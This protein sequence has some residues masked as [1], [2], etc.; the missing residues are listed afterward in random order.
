MLCFLEAQCTHVWTPPYWLGQLVIYLLWTSTWIHR[1]WTS[2]LG[3]Y[4]KHCI[5]CMEGDFT[6]ED[7]T[8]PNNSCLFGRNRNRWM[9]WMTHD[10]WHT[11]KGTG[12]RMCSLLVTDP[13][14]LVQR[15]RSSKRDGPPPPLPCHFLHHIHPDLLSNDYSPWVNW[16]GIV[17]RF[18]KWARFTDRNIRCICRNTTCFSK[19][20]FLFAENPLQEHCTLQK[21][22]LTAWSKGRRPFRWYQNWQRGQYL[23]A[24]F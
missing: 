6:K 16:V 2:I 22:V 4:N 12:R 10:I 21:L 20:L 24:A 18:W 23:E 17:S 15:P 19:R 3:K 1:L 9:T 7:C 8:S 11:F 13:T 14:S 5:F